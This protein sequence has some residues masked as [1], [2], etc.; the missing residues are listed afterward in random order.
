MS[1]NALYL[2]SVYI[3]VL[4]FQVFQNVMETL[5]LS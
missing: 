2:H 4:L 3:E 1:Y 5:Q